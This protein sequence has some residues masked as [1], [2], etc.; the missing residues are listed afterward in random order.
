M[1]VTYVERGTNW[2]WMKTSPDD[3]QE[4]RRRMVLELLVRKNPEHL[5][6]R[7]GAER[8]GKLKGG[9]KAKMGREECRCH[10]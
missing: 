3:L 4:D 1:A 6:R 8:Y 2:D 10:E 5:K 7:K 9:G